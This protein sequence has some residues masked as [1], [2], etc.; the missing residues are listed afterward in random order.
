MGTMTA[1]P[2][3]IR[4]HVGDAF[5][6]MAGE[7]LPGVRAEINEDG[8]ANLIWVES[9]EFHATHYAEYLKGLTD[10]DG[11]LTDEAV[12]ALITVIKDRLPEHMQ[13]LEHADHEQWEDEPSVG[14]S[15]LLTLPK[16]LD[17]SEEEF[18][19]AAYSFYAPMINGTDPGT[20]NH[21]YF[22]GDMSRAV[23][24]DDN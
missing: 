1:T 17:T 5:Y 24:R 20:F 15:L 6:D 21:P 14:L 3:T 7:H 2:T 19:A 16:G 23:E 22:I 8:T 18:Y 9:L 13:D 10:E 12:S 11:Y 4:A